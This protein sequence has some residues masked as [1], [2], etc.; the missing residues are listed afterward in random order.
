[1]LKLVLLRH[2]QSEW[3]EENRFTGWTDVDLSRLELNARTAGLD[4]Q[5]HQS[6]S[7]FKASPRFAPRWSRKRSSDFWFSRLKDGLMEN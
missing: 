1:M 6:K 2:G 3:N 4:P 7:G 5:H